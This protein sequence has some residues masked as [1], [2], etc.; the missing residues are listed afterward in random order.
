MKPD[1]F[2]VFEL[3]ERERRYLVPLYQRPYVWTQDEQ[4]NPLWLD[5]AEKADTLFDPDADRDS[6]RNHFLGAV[7]LNRVDT[8]GRQVAAVDIIDGQQRLTTLQVFLAALRDV[9]A[10]TTDSRL[11]G[12]LQRLTE[13]DCLRQDEVERFKVWPTNADRAAYESVLTARSVGEVKRRHP[14]R[15]NGKKEIPRARLVE[16]YLFF[17]GKIEAYVS[18]TGDGK[19]ENAGETLSLERL[20]AIFQVLRRHLQLVVIEL[21]RD[22]DP[23][24]IFET[25]NARG[26]PLLPS[27][28]IRN[29]AFLQAT[30]RGEEVDR[31]YDQYW[32]PY[33]ETPAEASATSDLPFWK[34]LERQGRLERPR[35]DLFIFHYLTYQTESDVNIGHL[36]REFREWWDRERGAQPVE[37]ELAALHT[38]SQIFS[39]FFLP[40]P[41][42]RLGLFIER[43]R[44][45]D[46]ATVYPVLLFLLSEENRVSYAEQIA[47]LEDLESFLVRRM[48]CELTTKNYN[49]LFLSLLK[50]MRSAERVDRDFVRQELLSGTG[51][52]V[53]WP[54]DQEFSLRILTSPMY[55]RLKPH[56]VSMLL[57]ALERRMRNTKQEDVQIK[58]KLTVEHVLPREYRLA[59]YPLPEIENPGPAE[60]RK[61]NRESALNTLGNLTLVTQ[62]LNSSLSN[63][64]FSRKRREIAMQSTLRLNTYFQELSDSDVWDE[65]T[66]FARGLKMAQALVAI[67]PHPTSTFSF[68]GPQT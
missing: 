58:S 32:L 3:F 52:A 62:P 36:F 53:R 67:W 48:V 65:N 11:I 1:K 33:D 61:A 10:R 63:A 49:R 57:Q 12:G 43:L 2:T 30:R 19:E 23:Q 18:P 15:F 27:D 4:W 55:T 22:D 34:Q 24:V 39:T 54:S 37:V 46:T 41:N 14:Q 40:D 16:A 38:H 29:F 66:I 25:L 6:L 28:L 13:N 7:V 51:D 31:L 68:T 59:D 9:A 47:I 26:Q 56:R 44:V 35:L 50:K 5:I 21:E 42:T 45:L 60:E 20:T 64:P 8:F 17:V